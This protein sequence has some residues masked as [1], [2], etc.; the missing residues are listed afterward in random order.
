MKASFFYCKNYFFLAFSQHLR[1]NTLTCFL[2]VMMKFYD[3]LQLNQAGSKE[4]IR[5]SEDRK[6]KLYH[7]FVYLFKIAITVGFCFL[8]VTSFSMA[9]GSDN[10][11]VGVVV[12]LYLLVFR[13]S[14]FTVKTNQSI[15]LIWLFYFL[16]AFMPRLANISNPIVG[17]FINTA[18]I[19]ILV[20]LGCHDPRLYNQSTLVLSYLLIYGY[21]VSGSMY[22]KRL[23]ALFIGAILISLVFYFKHSTKDYKATIASVIRSFDLASDT[24]RWQ[25]CQ[26][27]CVPLVVCIVELCGVHRSMW[28]GIAAMSV[29]LPFMADTKKRVS[30][31][32]IG[33]ICG[34][35]VFV[36]LYFVLPSS[37][38]AFIGI[39]GG[40]GVGLSAHY[41][42]QAI[43]NTFGA[44]AIASEL[45]GFKEAL[46]LRIGTNV[47]G[48]VFALLFC[49][50]AYKFQFAYKG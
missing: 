14:H 29:I 24:T 6:A 46:F 2:E 19:A 15:L 34:V 38:Y 16:M 22:Q 41:N 32:I 10:S 27:L 37:I 20:I 21:D 42:F 43:F 3:E 28:A 1:Y 26:I 18:S 44:L 33:N 45:Y 9:F 8:F 4:L 49:V 31:R 48:V 11:I 13:N 25:V 50:L 40:I 5:K 17:L 39:I 7:I 47:F 30:G 12:L 36:I 23:L 35:I